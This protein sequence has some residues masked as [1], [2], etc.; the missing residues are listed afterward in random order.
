MTVT[1][2][3]TYA[4]ELFG[5]D[6][7]AIKYPDGMTPK[8]VLTIPANMGAVDARAASGTDPACA[9]IPAVEYDGEAEVTFALLGGAMFDA[10]VAGL[11]YDPDGSGTTG[12]EG[13]AT[14]D[15]ASIVSGGRKNDTS[16]TI[17]IERATDAT[18]TRP[19]NVRAGTRAT[20]PSCDVEFAAADSHTISFELPVLK[21]LSDSLKFASKAKTMVKQVSL[22][23]ESRVISGGL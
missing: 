4:S 20:A 7:A 11:M 6:H 1:P 14:G 8:V 3:H 13:T 5:P 10:N 15:V 2:V 17:K 18:T 12:T 16:I 21:N 23:A 9:A 22:Q 19:V